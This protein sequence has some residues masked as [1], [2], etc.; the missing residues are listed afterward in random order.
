MWISSNTGESTNAGDV[1]VLITQTTEQTIGIG[2]SPHL[3]RTADATT[4]D[5]ARTVCV[6]SQARCSVTSIHVSPKSITIEQAV[7]ALALDTL[8][9]FCDTILSRA[10]FRDK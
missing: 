5:V 1:G 10:N 4:A 7:S 3:F 2:I 6:I 9:W 8:T